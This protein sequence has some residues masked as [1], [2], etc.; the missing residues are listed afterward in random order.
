MLAGIPA[1][2]VCWR[3]K[4]FTGTTTKAMIRMLRAYGFE[5]PSQTVRG[6][7]AHPVAILGWKDATQKNGHLILLFHGSFYCPSWGLNP[8]YLCTAPGGRVVFHIP[9]TGYKGK[10]CPPTITTTPQGNTLFRGV[11]LCKCGCLKAVRPPRRVWF[12]QECVDAWLIKNVYSFARAFI[13]KRDKGICQKCGVDTLKVKRDY[14]QAWQR[15]DTAAMNRL[16][17]KYPYF[18]SHKKYWQCDHILEQNEGGSHDPANLQTLCIECHMKKTAHYNRTRLRKDAK[19][20]TKL[21][22]L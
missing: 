20:V 22:S 7:S 19:R 16:R 4:H 14:W 5:C 21:A 13:R 11:K 12:S 9:I 2:D 18:V 1:A 10:P 17:K 8:S 3:F 6:E 15:N